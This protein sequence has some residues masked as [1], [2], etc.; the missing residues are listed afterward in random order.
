MVRIC[1]RGEY[2]IGCSVPGKGFTWLHGVF[3]LYL[4][5][6]VVGWGGQIGWLR[7]VTLV[8]ILDR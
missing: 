6:L 3:V 5:G 2:F 7:M 4:G 1:W 8:V